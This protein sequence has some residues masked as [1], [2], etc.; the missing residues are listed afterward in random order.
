MKAIL[1]AVLIVASFASSFDEVKSIVSNDQCASSS[2]EL[3]KP[4]INI[5]IQKLKQVYLNFIPEL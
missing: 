2:I 1:F 4:E 3:I 5:Q